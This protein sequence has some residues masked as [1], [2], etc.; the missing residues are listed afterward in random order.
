[1]LHDSYNLYLLIASVIVAVIACFIA[2]SLDLFLFRY[3]MLQKLEKGIWVLNGLMLGLA[4]WLMHFIGMMAGHIP[5]PYSFDV[6]LSLFSYIIAAIASILAI[7]LSS[8]HQLPK[9][10]LVIGSILMGAGI[11]GMH[12]VGMLSLY[13]PQHKIVYDPMIVMLSVVIAILGSGLAFGLIFKAKRQKQYRLRMRCV[14]ALILAFSIVIM[15]YV[16]M[17]A[18]QF[19]EITNVE[20]LTAYLSNQRFVLFSMIFIISLILVSGLFLATLELRLD[21]KNKELTSLNQ[22]LAN[23]A[24]QDYL[25]KLHN[26]FYLD[27][28]A[29]RI[30]LEHQKNHQQIAFIYIDVDHFKVIND[31]F[32][33]YVGDQLLLIIVDRIKALIDERTQLI[34]LGGDEFLLVVEQSYLTE[35]IHIAESLI[36]MIKKGYMIE[37]REIKASLSIGIAMYPEHGENLKNLLINAD[38]A[39]F[40]SKEQGRNTYRIYNDS[41][42]TEKLKSEYKLTHDLANAI[43]ERQFN[44]FYQ[45]KF[46]AQYNIC[47]VEALIRWMHPLH[48]QVNPLQF[49]DLAEKA[50]LIVPLGYWVMEETCRQ[51]QAWKQTNH[52]LYPVA[53]NL[54]ARQF[55]HEDLSENLQKLLEKYQV[56]AEHIIIEITENTMLRSVDLS[57]RAFATLKAMG[58]KIAIDDFGTGYSSFSYLKDFQFDELKIDRD[59]ITHLVAESKEEAILAS[60]I[61]LAI[62]LG[63][64][65]TA[66]GVET[67][68]QADILL[69]LGCHQLQG[70]LL[71]KPMPAYQLENFQPLNSP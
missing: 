52:Q 55:E 4:I 71:A 25:T 11:V 9:S 14:A 10:R 44:L 46:D 32:G 69:R 36:Q 34:R 23:L 66:E 28:Y 60:I 39:M 16:G 3:K 15:H 40:L 17:S 70:F 59:F 49:I 8:H 61:Q 18:V 67:Q 45:P 7:W 30:F 38:M 53:V 58:V 12:Y 6:G 33:H 42:N 13:T 26:R 19:V 48:G 65:V 56:D 27:G 43:D 22:D 63:L 31:V 51:I 57:Q 41:M 20:I 50:G 64:T 21:E 54:S 35:A 24:L 62:K 2:L 68:E 29:E 1:M 47:G 37:D 5:E